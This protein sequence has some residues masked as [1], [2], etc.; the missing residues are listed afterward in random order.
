MIG[1]LIVA[2]DFL[3]KYISS[4]FNAMN[5]TLTKPYNNNKITIVF[6]VATHGL[7]IFLVFIK[8]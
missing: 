1:L 8:M 6:P 3:T 2:H 7:G 5:F 4:E